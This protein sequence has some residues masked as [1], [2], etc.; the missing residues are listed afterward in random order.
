MGWRDAAGTAPGHELAAWHS[1]GWCVC[2]IFRVWLACHALWA[3]SGA[4]H[5]RSRRGADSEPGRV[6][7]RCYGAA[8]SIIVA[9]E[10]HY[11]EQRARGDHPQAR[12]ALLARVRVG[13]NYAYPL[14]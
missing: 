12:L 2:W 9:P 3:L 5:R 14:G 13:S 4:P 1:T 10:D 8:G 7:E 6:P 11:L